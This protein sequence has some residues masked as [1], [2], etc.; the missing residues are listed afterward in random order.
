[1]RTACLYILIVVHLCANTTLA[2]LLKMPFLGEHF[3]AHQERNPR[4]SMMQFLSMHYWGKDINDKDGKEDMKLP[5]KKLSSHSHL[6]F[7]TLLR[8]LHY[9]KDIHYIRSVAIYRENF[10]GS[11]FLERLY[12]P[13]QAV[14]AKFS[15]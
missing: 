14:L 2:E 15:L 9:R 11:L 7:Q 12:R 10:I 8:S 3:I 4:I 6:L 5:F 1:M 13:P